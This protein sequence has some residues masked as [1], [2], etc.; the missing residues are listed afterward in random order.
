M[1]WVSV[2]SPSSSTPEEVQTERDGSLLLSVVRTTNPGVTTLKFRNKESGNWRVVR[3]LGGKL[4]PPGEEGWGKITYITVGGNM[5][6]QKVSKGKILKQEE[7]DD[8][9]YDVCGLDSQDDESTWSKSIYCLFDNKNLVDKDFIQAFSQFGTVMNVGIR[10][11]QGTGIVTFEDPKIPMS[12]YGKDM[13]VCGTKLDI[14]EPESDDKESRKLAVIF[15][16]EE[17]KGKD[18]WGHFGRYG[19]VTDVYVPRPFKYFGFVTYSKESTCRK[20]YNRT[21]HL[22]G[23]EL[24]IQKPK[25]AKNIY[26]WGKRGYA[27]VEKGWNDGKTWVKGEIIQN[28][29][30]TSRLGVQ[31]SQ[32]QQTHGH[33]G[34]GQQLNYNDMVERK[35]TDQLVKRAALDRD[36]WLQRYGYKQ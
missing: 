29:F 26:Q 32:Q 14:K 28:Q 12:L 7:T 3:C 21:H 30:K 22:K 31:V 27:N 34:P 19:R 5:M 6:D 16:N 35:K 20:L 13:S 1:V 15:R 24:R 17:I 2:C 4:T 36:E 10:A 23:S 11:G 18:L 25:G 33:S 8:C 9:N